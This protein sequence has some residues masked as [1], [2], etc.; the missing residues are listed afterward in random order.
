MIHVIA[1]IHARPGRRDAVL[2][3]FRANVAAVHA[4]PGCIEY[5]AVVDL[6]DAPSFQAAC[7]DDAFMVI[8]KWKDRDALQAH[9]ASAHMAA[10]AQRTADLV[11]SRTIHIL[12]AI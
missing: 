8:E 6:Q 5:A 10:Y 11:A 4:E 3:E 7:G 2:R 12:S 9:A 1:M